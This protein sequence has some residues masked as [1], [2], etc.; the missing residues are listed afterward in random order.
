M[1]L[2]AFKNDRRGESRALQE[3]LNQMVDADVLIQVSPR[4]LAEKYGTRAK[5]YQRSTAWRVKT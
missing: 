5:C 4:H 2:A 3:V 1:R